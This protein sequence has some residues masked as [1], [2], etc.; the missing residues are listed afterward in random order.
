MVSLIQ[1][2]YYIEVIPLYANHLESFYQKL[3]MNFV[4]SLFCIYWDDHMVLIFQFVDVVYHIDRFVDVEECLHPWDN[5]A[6]NMVC[7]FLMYIYMWFANI[8][9]RFA[10]M[11]ISDIDL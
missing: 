8:L 10:S 11:F 5:R 2:F 3:V 4:K 9:L 6:L 1:G 7:N